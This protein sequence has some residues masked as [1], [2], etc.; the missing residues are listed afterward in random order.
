M[1]VY[2]IVNSLLKNLLKYAIIISDKRIGG[3]EMRFL[4]TGD[5]HLDSAFAAHGAV[6]AQSCRQRQR[7]LLKRIFDLAK[8]ESCDMVLVAG[9]MLDTL[10]ASFETRRACVS[11]FAEF[12]GPVVIAPGNHDYYTVGGFYASKDMPSNVYVFNTS[13]LQY[14]DFPSLSTTVAGYAFTSPSLLT[15]P[16]CEVGRQREQSADI[17][18]LLA[19]AD[20]N[21]PTSRYAPVTEGD[22]SRHGFD[23]V[24]LGHVHNSNEEYLGGKARYCGFPEGRAFDE[25]GEGGVYIVDI[26]RDRKATVTRHNISRTKYLIAELSLDGIATEADIIGLIGNKILAMGAD[27][28]THVRLE[29]TGVLPL[30]GELDISLLEKT[31]GGSV[32]SL[33]LLDET[34]CLPDSDYLEKDITLK[35]ELYRTLR[36]ML[37]TDDA[38]ERALALRALKIGMAAIEG[39]DFT[40]KGADNEDK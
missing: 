35:G 7:E 16:L 20:V 10:C 22:L 12:G 17:L 1:T 5:L 31:C 26:G 34:L 25:L 6:G 15:S 8:S 39:R 29:L 28:H 36:P 3:I 40:D 11:A 13:E 30:D 18:V 27:G 38:S 14:F 21:S 19:H 4:H 2:A 33:E 24:A 23:Y 37:Y 9:D 32:A